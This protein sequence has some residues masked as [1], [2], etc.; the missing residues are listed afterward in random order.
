[1]ILSLET[2]QLTST[3]T[4]NVIDNKFADWKTDPDYSNLPIECVEYEFQYF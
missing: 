3:C 2:D 1:M 4:P